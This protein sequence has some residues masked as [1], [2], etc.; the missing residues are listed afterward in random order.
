[1]RSSD[2]LLLHGGEVGYELLEGIH[3]AIPIAD[4][5]GQQVHHLTHL[6]LL[7]LMMMMMMVNDDD[8]KAHTWSSGFDIENRSNGT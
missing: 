4:I 6:L 7:I 5:V 8:V 2:G 3:H 1:M